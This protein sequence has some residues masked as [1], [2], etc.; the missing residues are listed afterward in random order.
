M[1]ILKLEALFLLLFIFILSSCSSSKKVTG[2]QFPK[3]VICDEN[4]KC[5][6]DDPFDANIN[7]IRRCLKNTSAEAIKNYD[8]HS[9]IIKSMLT[10]FGYE[11]NGIKDSVVIIAEYLKI[12]ATVYQEKYDEDINKYFNK[13][14]FYKKEKE[15][16]SKGIILERVFL[17]AQ[18]SNLTVLARVPA[19]N[20]KLALCRYFN[21]NSYLERRFSRTLPDSFKN[22]L[23]DLLTE[24]S[25]RFNKLKTLSYGG[26]PVKLE[27]NFTQEYHYPNK[28]KRSKAFIRLQK[29]KP[30]ILSFCNETVLENDKIVTCSLN[31]K[32]ELTMLDLMELSNLKKLKTID[33][34]GSKIKNISLL[35]NIKTLKNIYIMLE[36]KDENEIEV[37]KKASPNIDLNIH[38]EK[39]L[40]RKSELESKLA[41]A[42]LEI[43]SLEK[44]KKRTRWK[45]KKKKYQ[46]E[47]EKIQEKI[48]NKMKEI[49]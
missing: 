16:V 39:E 6:V 14:T 30:L 29:V 18:I 46:K 15:E 9:I 38:G 32:T 8:G 22:N 3:G 33:L 35:G 20:S 10:E 43:K 41:Q 45:K 24:T 13:F 4:Y 47:I 7:T 37:L 28:K 19:E 17:N 12:L 21:I 31:S 11:T 36:Q 27:L 40:K 23:N 49:Q 25:K 2:K 1:K 34:R 42:R 44:K 5:E 26:A 48:E